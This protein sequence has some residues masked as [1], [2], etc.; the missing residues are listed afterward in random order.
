MKRIESIYKSQPMHLARIFLSTLSFVILFAAPVQATH[1]VGGAISYRCLGNDQYQITVRVYRDC[2]NAAPGADF[3]NPASIGI[4]D[5][6]GLLVADVRVPFVSEDTVTNIPSECLVIP[7]NICVN[8][9]TYVTTVNLPFKPGGYQLVYQ[10]CCRNETVQ[11]VVEPL[12]TGATYDIWLT[13]ESMLNCNSS[14]VFKEWPPIFICVN[15]ELNFDH[16]AIDIDGDSLV[17]KLIKPMQGGT[18]LEPKPQPPNPPPY[19]EVILVEPT[20]SVENFLGFGVPLQVDQQ[21]G[22]MTAEPT[23]LGQFVVGVSV[24]EYDRESGILLSTSRRDFQYNVIQCEPFEAVFNAPDT[25]CDQFSVQFD[26]QTAGADDFLWKVTGRNTSFTTRDRSPTFTFPDTGL[27]NVELIVEPNSVCEDRFSQNILVQTNS[28]EA[29]F[30]IDVLACT[31]SSYL[32]LTD[33]SVDSISTPVAWEWIIRPN[34]GDSIIVEGQF[35]IV[36]VPLGSKGTIQL[37]VTSQNGC[38]QSVTMPYEAPGIDLRTYLQDTI[39]ACVGTSINLNPATPSDV[40]LTYSWE[41]PGIDDPAAINPQVTVLPGATTYRLTIQGPANSCFIVAEVVVI[42]GE[43]PGLAFSFEPNCNGLS[44]RFEDLSTN[45]DAIEWII[46]DPFAP[47]FLSEEAQFDYAFPGPGSY[48]VYLIG[49]AGCTDTLLRNIE[50][51]NNDLDVGIEVAYSDCDQNQIDVQLTGQTATSDSIISWDW[52]LSDGKTSQLPNPIFTFNQS[53]DL[54][55]TLRVET[56]RGC[57]DSVEQE[58]QVNLIT[59]ILGRLPDT[60]ALCNGAPTALFPENDDKFTYQWSPPDGVDDPTS[61]NP[62]F[63]RPGVFTVIISIPNSATCRLDTQLISFLPEEINLDISVFQLPAD[64]EISDENG[65]SLG[66]INLDELEEL[67]IENGKVTS[68]EEALLLRANTDSESSVSWFL[69]GVEVSED[70]LFYLAQTSGENTYTAIATNQFGCKDTSRV[71]ID[72]EG[73]NVILPERVSV[74]EGEPISIVAENTDPEDSLTFNWQPSGAVI[75]GQG[76]ASVDIEASI[77]LQFISLETSNQFGCTESDSVEV[78]VVD[79]NHELRFDIEPLCSGTRVN[80]SNNSENAF[81]FLWHF[82]DPDNPEAVSTEENPSYTY[83][84]PG[85]YTALLTLQYDVSCRDTVEQTFTL[86]DSVAFEADF[87][88]D[89]VNCL[90]GSSTFQVKGST[91]VPDTGLMY[92]YELEDGRVFNTQ[93]FELVLSQGG[94]QSITLTVTSADSCESSITKVLDFPV[95]ELDLPDTTVLC[96]PMGISLN[97]GGPEEYSYDW[98]LVGGITDSAEVSPFVRPEITTSYPVT[99]STLGFES[100][101]VDDTITVMVPEDRLELNLPDTILSLNDSVILDA[102]VEAS[103]YKWEDENGQVISNEA[104]VSVLPDCAS[105][106]YLQVTDEFGCEYRDTVL[107]INQGISVVVN[108]PSPIKICEGEEVQL[109]VEN[110]KVCDTLFFAWLPDDFIISGVN[111][112]NPTFVFPEQGIY[113]VTGLVRNQYGILDTLSV[114]FRVGELESGLM[115]TVLICGQD[116]V[117]L[118]PNTNPDYTYEW[119]PA[120]NLDDP[121]SRNP[122]FSGVENTTYRVTITGNGC[123]VEDTVF[124][125]VDSLVALER[126]GNIPDTT[127]IGEELLLSVNKTGVNATT[128]WFAGEDFRPLGISGEELTI[129]VTAGSNVYFAIAS[130]SAGCADTVRYDIEGVNLE[131]LGLESTLSGCLGEQFDLYPDANPAYLYSWSPAELLEDPNVPNPRTR[132]LTQDTEFIATVVLPVAGCT[133]T[134]TVFVDIKENIILEIT[135]DPGLDVCPQT[136]VKLEATLEA[137]AS[138]VW[139]DS[140]GNLLG[141]A[142]T[143]SVFVGMEPLEITAI[144]KDSLGCEQTEA[145]T[146]RPQEFTTGLESPVVACSAIPTPLNPSGN[147]DYLYEWS[148]ST[149]LSDP[150]SVNPI[151]NGSVGQVYLVTVTDPGTGC[152]LEDSVEVIIQEH[153]SITLITN[154]TMICEPVPITLNVESDIPTTFEWFADAA[155]TISLGIGNS[156]EVMPE[157]GVNPYYVKTADQLC[158]DDR[159]VDTVV[160]EVVDFSTVSPDTLL[161]ICKDAITPLN[162]N[163]DDRFSYE[164]TP[165]GG[166]DDPFSPNPNF[167][168]ANPENFTVIITSPDGMCSVER[169]LSIRLNNPVNLQAGPD[170]ILCRTGNFTLVAD[171]QGG[172]NVMWASNRDFTEMV[173]SGDNYEIELEDGGRFYYVKADNGFGC[174]EVDSVFVGSGL[175]N[176][177]LPEEVLVCDASEGAVLRVLNNKPGQMLSYL[178]MPEEKFESGVFTEPEVVLLPG[179][180]GLISVLLENQ[181]GCTAE[182]NTRVIVEDVGSARIVPSQDTVEVGS[183]V[184]ISVVDCEDCQY[185]WSPAESLD[186]PNSSTVTA[187]PLETTEYFVT[188]TKGDCETVLSVTI[189]TQGVLCTEDNIFVPNAFT[190]NGDN[191]NDVLFVRSSVIDQLHFIIYNRWGQEVFDTQDQDIGW[192]G[193]FR[194]NELPPDVYGYFLRAICFDGSEI[195]LQG[196]VTLLR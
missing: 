51:I 84:G 54:T 153:P 74:C 39:F 19:D 27:Y 116:S 179:E 161:E 60:V 111:T 36:P 28:L 73:I 77:G 177:T 22:L 35:P 99:I 158:V 96:D 100:C 98:E 43:D 156:I 148:P 26:N 152:S 185:Q 32:F 87:S 53:Q 11:N 17:Y 33:R 13:E 18:F 194:G 41:G 137:G 72:L 76:T 115:D 8:T 65:N 159:D 146:I 175:I 121:N 157:E 107:V 78:V 118:G 16:S 61:A 52:S 2:F 171:H 46:G 12:E 57:V 14:P 101:S 109:E 169:M 95:V 196:N 155:M 184:Q 181:F 47:L 86:T 42:G 117:P 103:R 1:I 187:R 79:P 30:R 10:R 59:D 49:T 102:M 3:D 106:Y 91:S 31:D 15:D 97:P 110:Q 122:I 21:S 173:S 168:G 85:T 139:L 188:V 140:Q 112:P 127:C 142:D 29:D 62:V 126:N 123:A 174:T 182:L 165:G 5:R 63:L 151:F 58:I 145:L 170:T 132:P 172:Q 119:S 80:F 104:T 186:N 134:D 48:P 9:T 150:F 108:P 56:A 189:V 67:P 68:C 141:E 83:S 75:S 92:K 34:T 180:E 93:D 166:L 70:S 40:Q 129:E 160:V 113:L 37:N 178:W 162:P 45:A 69:N 25:V 167:N 114:E 143:V 44:Y 50:V 94:E 135:A 163:G 128:R 195:T 55:V 138:I 88:V 193:T 66:E 183:Q 154:D 136:F 90:P 192:D 38:M 125:V 64:F 20:Y 6:A 23:I 105:Y 71:V 7:P 191:Q 89:L 4:F 131:L 190:P 120:D 176:A 130:S 149:G 24:E 81:G 144:A 124:V 164:W 133:L 82:G 147:P